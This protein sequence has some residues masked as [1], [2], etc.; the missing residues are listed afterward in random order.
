MGLLSAFAP[1]Q[2]GPAA[3]R[4]PRAAADRK[5]F[6]ALLALTHR[7]SPLDVLVRGSVQEAAD[8]ELVDQVKMAFEN[9]LP[10]PAAGQATSLEVINLLAE[11]QFPMPKLTQLVQLDPALSA[12]VMKSANSAAVRGGAE[13]ETVRDALVRL[14]ARGVS[15]VAAIVA[16]RTLFQP[17]LQAHL[18]WV[19]PQLEACYFD[20]VVTARVAAELSLSTRG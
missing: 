17:N 10:V 13:I 4:S 15:R 12:G 3:V 5:P 20:A 16:A 6:D 11:P 2:A 1:H 19:R 8:P 9:D 7:D 14:G 18:V